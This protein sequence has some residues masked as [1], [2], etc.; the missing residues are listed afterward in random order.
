MRPDVTHFA[1]LPADVTERLAARGIDP[2]RSVETWLQA[3]RDGDFPITAAGLP[4][5]PRPVTYQPRRQ[6]RHA[7]TLIPMAVV[8]P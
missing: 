8:R 4:L 7:L 3:I 2:E 1:K 5:A 6:R